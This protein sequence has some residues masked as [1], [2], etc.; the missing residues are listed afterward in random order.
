MDS[1][2][3]IIEVNTDEKNFY[4][5]VD[6]YINSLAEKF[7]ENN[8]SL[9]KLI[10][11]YGIL[12]NT[13]EA[14][15][16]VNLNDACP[17]ELKNVNVDNLKPITIIESAKLY[18]CGSKTGRT[19]NCRGKCGTKTCPCKKDNVLCFTKCHSKRGGCLNIE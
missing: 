18:S 5:K 9:F 2:S 13:F 8:I 7:R 19:C 14:A 17:I 12:T 10:C 3:T 15:Q 4:D 11:Q 6:E 16:F 1:N